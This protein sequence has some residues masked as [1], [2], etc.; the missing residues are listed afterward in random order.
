MGTIISCLNALAL[1]TTGNEPSTADEEDLAAL[2]ADPSHYL[3]I[4]PEDDE[5]T[6]DDEDLGATIFTDTPDHVHMSVNAQT[7]PTPQ[8][9]SSATPKTRPTSLPEWATGYLNF[10]GLVPLSLSYFYGPVAFNGSF[11]DVLL[12][13]CG[14]RTMM[15]IDSVKKLGLTIQRTDREVHY[16]S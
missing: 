14:S 1:S 8:V 4:N 12:D 15:D 13:T 6:S 16:G 3:D 10:R 2:I 11:T 9:T 5:G 7:T